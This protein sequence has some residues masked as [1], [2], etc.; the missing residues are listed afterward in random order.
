MDRICVSL[1]E[2]TESK[3]DKIRGKGMFQK[4]ISGILNLQRN[5]LPVSTLF[6]L[7]NEN[8]ED[9]IPIIKLNEELGIE[10]LSVM[11]I[12]PTGRVVGKE[13]TLSKERWYPIFNKLTDMKKNGEIKLKFKIVPTN[14]SEVFWLYYFPLKFFNRLDDL[15]YWNQNI[16]NQLE[17]KK[18]EVS[19]QA[20]LR[21]C[22]IAYN[23]RCILVW[24]W[25]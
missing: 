8:V 4:T 12:C 6:T 2:S 22:S 3:H 9:L 1:D 18:R 23:G 24:R 15:K 11:V 10:Y 5:N 17:K 21:A 16:S 13:L 14:E 7:H 19:C 20:G 25:L